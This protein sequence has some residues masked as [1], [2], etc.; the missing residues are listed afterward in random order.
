MSANPQNLH[1]STWEQGMRET[2]DIKHYHL[3]NS[4]FGSVL[5]HGKTRTQNQTWL[6]SYFRLVE[7]CHVTARCHYVR[8]ISFVFHLP[9]TC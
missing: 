9:D 6:S 7:N 1:I 3:I 5:G 2:L 8:S 4:M